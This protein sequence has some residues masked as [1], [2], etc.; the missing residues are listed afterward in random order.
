M[1][2]EKVLLSTSKKRLPSHSPIMR[3]TVKME[4][5]ASLTSEERKL[6]KMMKKT[7]FGEVWCSHHCYI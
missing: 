3:Q 6:A 2:M 7:R 5:D 4:K 1:K